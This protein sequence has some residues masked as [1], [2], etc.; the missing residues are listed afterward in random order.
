MIW[1]RLILFHDGNTNRLLTRKTEPFDRL[2]ST[3]GIHYK[4][5]FSF[6]FSTS[7]HRFKYLDS[8]TTGTKPFGGLIGQ[9]LIGYEKLL[10]VDFKKTAMSRKKPQEQMQKKPP[11][12]DRQL[13]SKDQQYHD[14]SPGHLT[15]SN[16][17]IKTRKIQI[18]VEVKSIV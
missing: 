12:V 14:I 3:W 9:Q 7:C 10:V 18:E 16:S 11:E 5:L 1:N 17:P 2:N 13:L 15:S 4:G 6:C 8:D